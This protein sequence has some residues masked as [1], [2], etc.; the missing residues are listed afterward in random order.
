MER[1]SQID[2]TGHV[3]L[4]GVVLLVVVVF[5]SPPA[6]AGLATDQLSSSVD[7]V[8]TV[9]KDQSLKAPAMKAQRRATLMNL[10][11]D[12]FDWEEISKRSLGIYWKDRT[13]EEKKE[14]IKLFTDLLERTYMDK[15]ESYSGE[16][17][18]YTKETVEEQYALVETKIIT[19]QDTEV[20]VNYWMMNKNGRWLVYDVSVEGVSLV[21]NYR[22]QFNEI[23][24]RSS[25]QELLKKLKEKQV[26]SQVPA[27]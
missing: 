24:A 20:A 16:K 11:N 15:I 6:V 14:F 7:K 10:S 12:L 4:L 1:A 23:L 21:K 5:C 26:S 8:L 17:I 22:T 2:G 13:P 3:K 18:I 19:K 9:L 27:S 25:Y